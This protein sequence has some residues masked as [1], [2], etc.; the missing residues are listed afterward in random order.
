MSESFLAQTGEKGSFYFGCG[1]AV[2]G[3]ILLVLSQWIMM[4][5]HITEGLFGDPLFLS[6]LGIVITFSGFA[7]LCLRITCPNCGVR[8]LWRAAST[9][10]L[11]TWDQSIGTSSCPYCGYRP[12]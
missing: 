8:I 10:R 11:S 9:H 4:G 5:W 1:L 3:G 7:W 2:A 6:L 12:K